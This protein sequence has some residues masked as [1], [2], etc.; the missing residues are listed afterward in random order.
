M[1]KY[2]MMSLTPRVTD[3]V[4]ALL[5]VMLVDSTRRWYGLELARAAGVGHATVYA[6]LG[7]LER[8]GWVEGEWET[9]PPERLS[10]PRRRTYV[11]SASGAR[12]GGAAVEQQRARLS[13]RA[14]PRPGR[15]NP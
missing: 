9:S 2:Q 12:L 1:Q 10:R 15:E 4:A 5:A 8:A 6:A 11:L 3:K 13:P 14:Q 7:R